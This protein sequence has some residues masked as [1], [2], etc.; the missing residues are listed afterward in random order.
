[1]ANKAETGHLKIHG[2]WAN[3]KVDGVTYYDELEEIPKSNHDDRADATA[4]AIYML[5]EHEQVNIF[6]DSFGVLGANTEYEYMDN[7]I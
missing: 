1:M 7:V 2:D 6:G 4:K 5:S 3:K